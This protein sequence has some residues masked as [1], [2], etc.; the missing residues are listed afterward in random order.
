MVASLIGANTKKAREEFV[1]EIRAVGTKETEKLRNIRADQLAGIKKWKDL[2]PKD[3]SFNAEK[4][5]EDFYKA[6]S[7]AL[8][9]LVAAK[10]KQVES[11]N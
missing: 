3:V 10:V 6:Q 4:Q 2:L 5:I 11:S 7:K 9:D 1:K 8:A